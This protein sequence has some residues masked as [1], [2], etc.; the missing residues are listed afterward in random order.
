MAVVIA[1]LLHKPSAKIALK[2]Y[3]PLARSS[4]SYLLLSPAVAH[5]TFPPLP[6]LPLFLLV[7]FASTG[8]RK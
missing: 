4:L 3:F 1:S 5:V 6:S 7:F 8:D 2:M